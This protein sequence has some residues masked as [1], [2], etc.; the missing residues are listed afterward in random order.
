MGWEFIRKIRMMGVK[1]TYVG[2]VRSCRLRCWWVRKAGGFLF[3]IFL[4]SCLCHSVF[5][6]S[7]V[8]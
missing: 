3:I 8:F 6:C 1:G 7:C 5:L 4:S 2:G